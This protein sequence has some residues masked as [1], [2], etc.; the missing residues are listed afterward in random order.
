MDDSLV[1]GDIFESFLKNVRKV[2]Q[3]CVNSNLVLK[4][5][6]YYF[7]VKE[8]IVLGHKI[9]GIVIQVSQTRVEVIALLPL[10]ISIKGVCSFLG[11]WRFIKYISKIAQILCKLLEENVV[12]MCV[13]A[14]M[15]AIEYLKEKLISTPIIV[16]TT[17]NLPF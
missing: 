8:D 11:Y 16:A 12:V 7:M 17:W 6:K 2:L 4:W 15:K 14:C 3:R 5:E 9:L 13:D 1:M 10:P